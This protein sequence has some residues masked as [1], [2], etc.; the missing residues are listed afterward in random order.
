MKC[1][2]QIVPL[3]ALALCAQPAFAQTSATATR[4]TTGA[5][6]GADAQP[7]VAGAGMGT[8]EFGLFVQPTY[9]GAGSDFTFGGE[10]VGLDS[11][12]VVG[13]GARLGM[14]LTP[15][16]SVE[17]DAMSASP[18]AAGGRSVDFRSASVRANYNFS[19]PDFGP[20]TSMLVG[21]G[22]TH[23]QYRGGDPRR[24]TSDW[25][26]GGIAGARFGL[27]GPVVARGD[28]VADYVPQSLNIGV[29][30]GIGVVFGGNGFGRGAGTTQTQP[31]PVQPVMP[32]PPAIQDP[33]PTIGGEEDRAA[34]L[35]GVDTI[36]LS[37]SIFFDYDQVNI[38][39][40]A[41]PILE[42]K[43]RWLNANP[44]LVLRIEGHADDRGQ[45]EYNLSLSQ[46]RAAETQAW[47]MARGVSGDRLPI[48]GYGE[49]FPLCLQEPMTDACHQ[50]N[51][52]ADFR[53]MRVG[54]PRLVAPR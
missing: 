39:A 3:L 23:V 24:T 52:R 35:A 15:V 13:F 45:D 16:W 4:S 49:E 14:F 43:L 26:I 34:A 40:D 2:R 46:R 51:R 54:A 7:G 53:I 6:T 33:P 36:P 20:R 29:R 12:T 5:A 27:G 42:T 25:G 9:L 21:A 28:I 30:L 17:V 47:F 50:M 18:D 11:R 48:V 31:Q 8:V 1:R 44:R 32:T 10:T 41:I 37:R 19:V 38:R 22:V